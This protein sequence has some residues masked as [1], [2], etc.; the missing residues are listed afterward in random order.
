MNRSPNTAAANFNLHYKFGFDIE[1]SLAL[2]LVPH[3][4][5]LCICETSRRILFHQ[6]RGDSRLPAQVRRVFLL[7]FGHCWT[8]QSRNRDCRTRT[9]FCIEGSLWNSLFIK[10]KSRLCPQYLCFYILVF[11][12]IVHKHILCQDNN[13]V[14]Q[15][16]LMAERVISTF[17]VNKWRPI[18][19]LNRWRFVRRTGR[20]RAAVTLYRVGKSIVTCTEPDT[21]I[22]HSNI[23]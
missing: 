14:P 23:T 12:K 10:L 13:L 15:W 22:S 20:P 3:V 11:W 9:Q 6:Y 21:T 5:I 1:L 7:L 8:N 19:K 18:W 4:L 16:I 2:L 17:G